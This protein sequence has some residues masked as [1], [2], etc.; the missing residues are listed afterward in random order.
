MNRPHDVIVR[1]LKEHSLLDPDDVAAVQALSF[2]ARELEPNEDLIRQGDRPKACAIVLSGM[3]GRYHTLS[4]GKRQYLSFHLP[5]D[6]PDA[7]ALFIE[8]MDHSVCALG[9]ASL[10]LVPHEEILNMFVRR[11]A[12]GIAVWRETLLDSAIF[13]DAITNNGSRSALGRT[14]HLFCELYYRARAAGVARPG[15]V[16]LPLHQGVLGE[17]LGLSTVTVNRT[18]QALRRTGAMDFRQ[19][20][21][22]VLDW[23]RLVEIGEFD[24][25][26]LSLKRPHRL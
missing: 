8:R 7:Q 2:R 23:K 9:G 13:R 16:R 14:A 17:A 18:V 11:P 19:G 4:G 26:Y 20:M 21:L 10:V 15:Q 1:K 22:S 12:V 3:V 6:M 5:G 24:P 25:A